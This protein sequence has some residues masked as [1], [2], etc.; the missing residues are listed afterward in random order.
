QL[1]KAKFRPEFLN[2][3]DETVVFHAL[4]PAH[5]RKIVDLQI[6]TLRKRLADRRLSL[7]VSN[8]ALDLLAKEGFDPQ[9]G[10]RPLKRLIQRKV[11]NPLAVMLLE[12]RFADGDT[13]TVR[14]AKKTGE[15]DFGKK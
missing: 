13:V 8:D 7:E 1:L 12:G 3:I 9:F 5:L 15:L 10:A 6:E 11:Q 14:V 4:E 2:R